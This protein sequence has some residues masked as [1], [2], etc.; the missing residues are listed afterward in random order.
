V[1][2][3]S[4]EQAVVI[5][6]GATAHTPVAAAITDRRGMPMISTVRRDTSQPGYAIVGPAA[7]KKLIVRVPP[8]RLFGLLE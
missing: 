7:D 6:R 1:Q 8:E 3:A 5:R 2:L 4:G